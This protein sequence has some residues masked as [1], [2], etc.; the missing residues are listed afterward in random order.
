MTNPNDPAF[1]P[2]IWKQMPLTKREYF[3]GLAMQ[4]ILG[5]RAHAVYYVDPQ[6]D[7]DIITAD[8]GNAVRIADA[9]I[10]ELNKTK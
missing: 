1:E 2:L 7:R 10:A 3:A 5:T 4:G 6:S 9:L 8:V